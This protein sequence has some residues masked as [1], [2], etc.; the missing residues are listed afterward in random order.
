MARGALCLCL[1]GCRPL[2]ERGPKGRLARPEPGFARIVVTRLEETA[3]RT[4]WKWSVIGDRNWSVARASGTEIALEKTYPLNDPRQRGGCFTWECD[5]TIEGSGAGRRWSVRLHGSNGA[6]ATGAGRAPGETP[7][8]ILLES[9]AAL[10]LPTTRPLAAVG[11]Q[12]I[13]LK[14]AL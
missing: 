2:P 10:R 14:L 9:D 4:R 6:T 7:P 12:E 1:L 3:E 5:L 13:T 8:R 11:G